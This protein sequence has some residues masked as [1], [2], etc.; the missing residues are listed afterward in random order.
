MQPK[1]IFLEFKDNK[2]LPFLFGEYN[3]HLSHLEKSLEVSIN[4]RGNTL[5]ISGKPASILLAEE[6]LQALYN[7]LQ[8]SDVQEITTADI[9]AEL[10]FLNAKDE[11]SQP[12]NKDQIDKGPVIKTRNKTINPRS[13]NQ[14]RYL[15]MIQKKDMVFGLGP[16]GTGKTYLAVAAGVGMYLEGNVSRLIFCRPAV[17]AGERLGFL[18]GDMKEKIDPY[19]RPIYDALHDML[20]W[21]FMM[22]KMETGEIEI[23]PL[24]FMRG[25]TLGHAFVLL[26]EAQ[27]ATC[28]QMK[29]FLTRMGERSRMVIT[30]DLT[31]TDL[32]A[33][34]CSG[35]SEAVDILGGVDEIGFTTFDKE[36]VIRHKLV[37]K[38]IHAYDRQ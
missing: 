28:S 11:K 6:A 19:L 12:I 18:P 29:M 36:D 27:N 14:A 15:E 20:P 1:E 24:A 35:L 38:I 7:K 31:Q 4:D 17:E 32:P 33:G 10:R 26:D 8:R 21:D 30:G 37:K 13:P 22:K 3:A 34:T 25:R 16:A 2:L 9:D 23:A 5:R